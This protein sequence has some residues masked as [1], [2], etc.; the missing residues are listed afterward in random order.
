M[1]NRGR[2]IFWLISY[3]VS[4]AT[5]I[6]SFPLAVWFF[7]PR[8]FGYIVPYVLAI[9]IL[10]FFCFVKKFHR[11][12]GTLRKVL[13]GVLCC[14]ILVLIGLGIGFATGVLYFT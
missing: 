6:C 12:N 10:P 13:F 1:M 7:Y 8:V 4:I 3:I 9:I 11:V 2:K 5:F 14:P